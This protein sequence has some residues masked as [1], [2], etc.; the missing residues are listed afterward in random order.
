VRFLNSRPR[1][2]CKK[3]TATWRYRFLFSD[4]THRQVLFRSVSL[5][6]PLVWTTAPL[7]RERGER[8]TRPMPPLP[9]PAEA[10]F[11]KS[12]FFYQRFPFSPL[13]LRCAACPFRRIPEA[14]PSSR[15]MSSHS[16]NPRFLF[17]PPRFATHTFPRTAT[18]PLLEVDSRGRTFPRVL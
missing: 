9:S 11:P 8:R 14:L 12:F 2:M 18:N 5:Q 13:P 4:R 1:L 6:S 7:R 10:P 16:R 3:A 15:R 17:F